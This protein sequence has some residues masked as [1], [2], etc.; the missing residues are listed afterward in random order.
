MAFFFRL[1]LDRANLLARVR[2][3]P[4]PVPTSV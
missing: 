4:T 3:V 1:E 2:G